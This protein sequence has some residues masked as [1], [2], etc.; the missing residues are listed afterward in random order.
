MPISHAHRTHPQVPA[1]L[2][3]TFTAMAAFVAHP[4]LPASGLNVKVANVL[5]GFLEVCALSESSN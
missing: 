5:E 3:P 2:A 4:S 1:L